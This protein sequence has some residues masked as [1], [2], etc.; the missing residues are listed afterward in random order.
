MFGNSLFRQFDND[1]FFSDFHARHNEHMRRMDQ[2]MGGMFN[3]FFGG[4]TQQQSIQDR[5]SDI[6]RNAVQRSGSNQM[7]PF[8][9]DMFGGFPSMFG[10]QHDMMQRMSQM[11]EQMH[12]NPNCHSYSSSTVMS[13]SNTGNGEPKMYQASSSTRT[14][15]GGVKE[16]RK[17]V[18][19]SESGI[20]K[21]AVG[22]HIHERGHRIEKSR[23]R[24]TGD[25]DE[26]QDFLNIGEDEV[27]TFNQ[28]WREKTSHFNSEQAAIRD[29]S[30]RPHHDRRP[31][32]DSRHRSQ[33][34]YRDRGNRE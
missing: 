5:R 27:D 11:Q 9:G 17:A 4:G 1:P 2:T 33:P 19:D 21:M 8:G 30:R 22:H 25:Q 12:N 26:Q 20:D 28:E 34:G 29:R 6:N 13:Y 32:A 10:G 16:T 14:A 23:N 24:R 15:P 31:I 18:R 3:P 7:M